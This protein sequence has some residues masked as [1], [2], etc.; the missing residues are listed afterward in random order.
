MRDTLELII[1]QIVENVDAVSV[2]ENLEGSSINYT[3]KVDTKDVGRVIGKDGKI[4]KAIRVLLRS[5]ANKEKKRIKIE[6]V[7]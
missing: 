6:F 2:T 4:A 3:V 7:D 1:K 5:I